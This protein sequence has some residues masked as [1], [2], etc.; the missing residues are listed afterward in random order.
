MQ[1]EDV[2]QLAAAAS[3]NGACSPLHRA[4]ST[5][6]RK[7]VKAMATLHVH[8]AEDVA[9]VRRLDRSSAVEAE[10]GGKELTRAAVCTA[11]GDWGNEKGT[12]MRKGVQ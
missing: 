10:W 8:V 4:D 2:E 3:A 7:W 9:V 6:A 11:D 1:I 12:A 5:R